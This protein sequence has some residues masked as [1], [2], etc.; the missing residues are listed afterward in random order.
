MKKFLFL[1]LTLSVALIGYSQSIKVAILDFENTSGK[2]EYDALGKAMS[3]M[4]I[5]DLKNN[6]HPKKVDFFER[7]QLNK[8]LDEQKLQKSKNFDSKTAVDFGKLSGVNYVFVGSV[9][10]LDG[11]CNITSKLVD[12]KT[13]KIILSKEANGKI[14]TW[15]Q[16]KSELAESIANQ[17]NNSVTL[18]PAYK[19]QNTTLATLNQYGKIITTMD[20]G[21]LEKAEQMRGLFE[22]TNP[23]FKYFK[24]IKE[25]IEKLKQRVAELENV[26]DVLTDAFEL[27]QKALS[28]SDYKSAVKYFEKFIVNPGNQEFIENRKLYAYGKLSIA[29]F[30]NGDFENALLNAIKANKIYC[31]YPETN[32]IELM[33]L[34]KLKKND[35][36]KKKYDFIIDSISFTNE[37]SFRRENKNELLDWK[38]MDGLFYGLI[39]KINK[40]ED[41]F[42]CY[43][44]MP[45]T[46][47]YSPPKNEF[48]IKTI[49]KE[50]DIDIN[51]LNQGVN[52]YEKIEKKLIDL[53]FPEL[54]SSDQILGFYKISYQYAEDLEKRKDYNAY[55]KHIEKEIHRME[56]FG[57]PC[58]KGCMDENQRVPLGPSEDKI[59]HAQWE[60]AQGVL[61]G[62]GLSNSMQEFYD[63]FGVLYGNFI[64]SE[65]IELVRL[66]KLNEA[67]PIYRN[68]LSI[69]V[70]DRN[71][72]FYSSYWDIILGLRI[73]NEE[74]NSRNEL[75]ITELEKKLNKKIEKRLKEL[76]IPLENFENLKKVKIASTSGSETVE[77]DQKVKDKLKWSKNIGITKDGLGNSFQLA[78]KNTVWQLYKDSVPAYCYYDFD[79]NNGE[80]YGKLYN[81]WAMKLLS[82]NPPKGWRIVRQKDYSNLLNL[83]S[84][85]NEENKGKNP[86]QQR[87]L[88]LEE[89][90]SMVKFKDDA[91]PFEKSG[92]YHGNGFCCIDAQLWLWADDVS[93]KSSYDKIVNIYKE[94]E[95]SF[96]DYSCRQCYFAI[97]LIEDK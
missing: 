48:K 12:V 56:K 22:E 38:T 45:K 41:D 17:L 20:N 65:L 83:D 90:L 92:Q 54:F 14:E 47:Y 51:L 35:E 94:G 75:S 74:F 37:L 33:S 78:N 58:V 50:N 63:Q 18:D 25:D 30:K 89:F 86:Y 82:S 71:S 52:Q 46:G 77:I 19:S 81:Y 84:L 8:L 85:L 4:L 87:L 21:D 59:K 73:I 29:Y 53:N 15:L 69:Y 7:A 43:E 39:G 66:G 10:V 1:I 36:A 55:K 13:S 49:L 62:L 97:K 34:M 16:L 93:E 68:I 26:T 80:K 76:N 95:L 60:K 57:I 64:F 67:A 91:L 5:T 9:F 31:Y 24:D 28:K 42:W 6:I 40:D 96:S 32:E 11:N 2:I 70:K 27:G 44:G 23:D 88:D 3:S 72:F 79:E 61:W